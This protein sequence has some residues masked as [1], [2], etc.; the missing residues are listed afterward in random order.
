VADGIGHDLP[1][2]TQPDPAP[3]LP[4]RPDLR[5]RVL[6]GDATIGAF[7]NLGSLAAAELI[8]RAGFDWT[9]IDLEHGMGFESELHAQLLAVQGT[10][11]AALVRVASAER[12]RVGRALDMGADGLMIPRL[13]TVAD[14][15]E[16][17]SWMRYPPQGIRGVALPNRGGGYGETGHAEL[18][19][20]NA[21][22][23][24]VFQVES[25]AA[26]DVADEIAA[27]EGVDVLFVGPADLSHSMGIPGRIDEPAF[28]RALDRVVAACRDHGKSAGILLRDAA[29]VP[30]A[31]MQGFTFLGIGSDGGYLTAGA[32]QGVAQARASLG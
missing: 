13:E 24:G 22:L 32:R 20:R 23:L 4:P 5:R 12:L 18:G 11:T 21:A 2:T 15:V 19:G 29:A 8:A 7:V 10:S 9:I 28:V 14:V 31:R 3:A 16:T 1:M 6:A 27:I 25:P 26:V 30:A 17:L